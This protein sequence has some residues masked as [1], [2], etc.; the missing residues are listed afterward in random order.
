M[1]TKEVSIL[2]RNLDSKKET[3]TLGLQLANKKKKQK[4]VIKEEDKNNHK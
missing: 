3:V 4:L 2:I 1:R